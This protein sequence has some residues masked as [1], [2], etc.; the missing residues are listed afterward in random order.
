[1]G[2]I[3]TNKQALQSDRLPVQIA[4]ISTLLREW[5]EASPLPEGIDWRGAEMVCSLSESELVFGTAMHEQA[6]P[7]EQ[8]VFEMECQE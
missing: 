5:K 4:S 7:A 3:T 6:Q 1:M 8:D 2:L